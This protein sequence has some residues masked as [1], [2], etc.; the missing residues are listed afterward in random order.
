[1]DEQQG[2]EQQNLGI[3]ASNEERAIA[4]SPS[5]SG[6]VRF[7]SRV[8]TFDSWRFR[9][10]RLLWFASVGTSGGYFFQQVVIGWLV[11]ELTGSALITT[12]ALSLDSLPQLIGGPI[13]GVLV[14]AW[15]RRKIL[16]ILPAYQAAMSIL[17]GVLVITGHVET[18]H[19]LVF[20]P[21]IG[22]AWLL[23][24]PARMA[25]TPQLVPRHSLMNAYSLTQLAFSTTRLAGPAIG[26]VVLDQ[27]G[28]GQ[29]LFAEG[30]VQ[31][32]AS[33]M[34]FLIVTERPPKV[35][36]SFRSVFSG[37]AEMGRY[38][39]ANAVIPGLLLCAIIP[40]LMVT[41]FT[42]GLMPVYNAEL[43]GGSGTRLGFLLAASGAGS[44]LGVIAVAT[45]AN[46]RGKGIVLLASMVMTAAVMALFSFNSFYGSALFLFLLIGA[47]FTASQTL[48]YALV[49][50]NIRDDLRGRVSG[51]VMAT[52]G[53]LPL[54]AVLAGLLA[55]RFS[56]ST[57]T[58]TAAVIMV[59]FTLGIGA[60]FRSVRQ[61]K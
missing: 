41:P 5:R 50:G 7:L 18:W 26:G 11:Y 37:L 56:A 49:Q 24:E 29:T 47:G 55:E 9:G 48:S 1:M 13:G 53:F 45:F 35:K 60:G 14:D 42:N 43:F 33:V 23:I 44:V 31:L 17:F 54:G 38:A 57:A 10:Y 22:S 30:G 27:F 40:P 16:I 46:M 12:L 34:A 20:V 6:P 19:I 39:K 28:P 52:W 4:L 21:L 2:N 15:D 3:T 36:V 8:R 32:A 59:V 61:V 58:L 51:L 25:I